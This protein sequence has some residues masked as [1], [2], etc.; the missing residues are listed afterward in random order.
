MSDNDNGCLSLSH[1]EVDETE[2]GVVSAI[3]TTSTT[4]SESAVENDD[5]EIE[6][7][8]AF[9]K[10]LKKCEIKSIFLQLIIIF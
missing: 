7:D 3:A 4:E 8:G 6:S 10:L 2:N 5:E 1:T 9:G